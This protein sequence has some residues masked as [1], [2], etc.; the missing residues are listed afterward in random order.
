MIK[1]KIIIE[2][3]NA[4]DTP[5]KSPSQRLRA[6]LWLWWDQETG[7]TEE[8]FDDFY[9][10]EMEKLILHYKNKLRRR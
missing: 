7:G 2:D 8:D 9:Q 4:P 3:R 6:V 5:K 10:L 1:E